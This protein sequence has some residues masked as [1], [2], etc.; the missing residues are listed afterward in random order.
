V[1]TFRAGH[2]DNEALYQ[3]SSHSLRIE[4]QQREEEITKPACGSGGGRGSYNT[5]LHVAALFLILI[6]ST[7]GLY[8]QFASSPRHFI[9]NLSSMCFPHH[10]AAVSQSSHPT[11]LP[12]PLE[13][14]WHRR[15][16]RNRIR[17]PLTYRLRVSHR[18]MS[19][20]LL[21]Q[22]LPGHGRSHCHDISVSRCHD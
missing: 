10:C 15:S 7:L 8:T 13:T 21:E 3:I 12:V 22:R 4:L 19:P 20:L 9:D 17:P 14:F 1:L 18:S 11:S 6:L 2:G 5:S 16:D